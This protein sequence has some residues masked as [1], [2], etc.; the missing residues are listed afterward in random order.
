MPRVEMVETD[1]SY[2]PARGTHP[3]A[4]CGGLGE[5]SPHHLYLRTGTK[6][7]QVSPPGGQAFPVCFLLQNLSF[8][9]GCLGSN[10]AD[11][12]NKRVTLEYLNKSQKCE[13]PNG[14]QKGKI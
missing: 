9:E 3:A 10:P 6:G 11:T 14:L 1:A 5:R 4:L 12:Q 13:I 2:F 7:A 8:S